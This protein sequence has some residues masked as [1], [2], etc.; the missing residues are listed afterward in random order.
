MNIKTYLSVFYT[1]NKGIKDYAKSNHSIES[2]Q[3][4]NM[5]AQRFN[6]PI[7]HRLPP[8]LLDPPLVM[9]RSTSSLKIRWHRCNTC[10]KQNA[11][12]LT[13]KNDIWTVNSKT[14]TEC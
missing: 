4:I 13:T 1:E 5:F 9:P 12:Q 7:R 3:P 2:E 8:P 14:M 11:K 10:T 6:L